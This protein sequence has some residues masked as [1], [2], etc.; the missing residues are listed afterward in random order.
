M[1]NY[2]MKRLRRFGKN[3]LDVGTGDELDE[4]LEQGDW[5]AKFIPGLV[6]VGGTIV[7]YINRPL[8]LVEQV[9]FALVIVQSLGTLIGYVT[10]KTALNEGRNLDFG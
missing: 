5:Y 10:L 3:L 2:T 1:I 4:H 6:M 9:L 7:A 8:A